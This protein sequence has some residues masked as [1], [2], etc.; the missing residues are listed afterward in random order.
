[1]RRFGVA[2][3]SGVPAPGPVEEELQ[4]RAGVACK[5]RLAH[6]CMVCVSA[7]PLPSVMNHLLDLV[8]GQAIVQNQTS[9]TDPADYR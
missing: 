6:A 7:R 2:G 5:Q 4:L 8:I 3:V 1:M 9:N